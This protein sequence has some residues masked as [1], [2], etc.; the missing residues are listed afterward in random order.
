MLIKRRRSYLRKSG[1]PNNILTFCSVQ[2]SEYA[3]WLYLLL[4]YFYWS[5]SFARFQAIQQIELLPR[6]EQPCVILRKREK[7]NNTLL[8]H[9]YTFTS[10][11]TSSTIFSKT[12]TSTIYIHILQLFATSLRFHNPIVVI[13]AAFCKYSLCVII[14]NRSLSWPFFVCYFNLTKHNKV[15]LEYSDSVVLFP[16]ISILSTEPLMPKVFQNKAPTKQLQYPL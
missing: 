6:D 5:K 2:R 9:F 16:F 8:F 1:V 14:P 10:L 13:G 11:P 4:Q 12:P 3:V 7:E 15:A